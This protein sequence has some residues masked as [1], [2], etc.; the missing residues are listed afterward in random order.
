MAVAATN[1]IDLILRLL[2]DPEAL[3]EFKANPD[4][5]LASCGATD[6]SPAD[7]H[8][9]LVLT[10]DEHHHSTP[11]PP[12]PHPHHGES[13]HAAAIRYINSYVTNNYVDDRDTNVD[14]SVNQQIDTGGGDLDQDIHTSSVTAS[15]DGAVAAGGDIDGSRVTTGNNNQVGDNN[16]KGDGNIQ[17]EDNQ[18]V[19]GDHNTTAF[20]T[21]AA[22]NADIDHASVSDGGALS[23]GSTALGSQTTADS[24]NETDTSNSTSADVDGSFNTHADQTLGSHNTADT[25]TSTD[26]HATTHND[27]FSHNTVDV[28]PV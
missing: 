22:N 1:L 14:N 3:A 7:V 18:A 13:E 15:G 5:V 21:G 6:L 16:I 20:G 2:N 4:A 11:P 19:N 27:A 26:S 10:D 8:D 28:H 17:G 9:A 24:H 25:D 12:P 23:V